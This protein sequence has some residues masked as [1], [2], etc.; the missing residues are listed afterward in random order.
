[1]ELGTPGP[2]GLLISSLKSPSSIS[3]MLS[4]LPF[5]LVIFVPI[6]VSDPNSFTMSASQ[7]DFRS[8]SSA[9]NS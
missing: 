8:M 3:T 6:V 2:S 7:V 4:L 5:L 9:D 1:M